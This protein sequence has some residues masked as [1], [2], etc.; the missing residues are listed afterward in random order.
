MFPAKKE[1]RM[2]EKSSMPLLTTSN[3]DM[4]LL[5]DEESPL[6]KNGSLPPTSMD[7]NMVFTLSTEFRG[8]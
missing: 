1:W 4:D 7:V 3:D 8:Y 5:D 2:K 6:I